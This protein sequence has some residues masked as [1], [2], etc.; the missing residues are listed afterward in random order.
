MIDPASVMASGEQFVFSDGLTASGAIASG[1]QVTVTTSAQSPGAPYLVSVANNVTDSLGTGVGVPNP[2]ASKGKFQDAVFLSDDATGTAAAGTE[3]QA[4]AVAAAGEWQMV[5]GGVP[6]GGFIDDNFS[7]HAALDLKGT[8]TSATGES[9]Q[10]AVNSDSNT[11]AGWG[12]ALQSWGVL[13]SGQTP[14][15]VWTGA[16]APAPNTHTLAVSIAADFFLQKFFPLLIW[17]CAEQLPG[18][19][20]SKSAAQP[21]MR[22]APGVY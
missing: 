21:W 17:K 19:P 20:L 4:G 6:M 14:R 18:L 12:Q 8:G 13:N 16:R 3:T 2:A 22:A 5:G 7:A 1:Q 11:R 15:S 9:I 10:R